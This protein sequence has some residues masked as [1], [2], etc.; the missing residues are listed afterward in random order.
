MGVPGEGPASVRSLLPK[1]EQKLQGPPGLDP[2]VDEKALTGTWAKL[3]WSVS[4]VRCMCQ[5]RGWGLEVELSRLGKI[6][7]GSVFCRPKL[8]TQTQTL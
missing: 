3:Y 5:A 4:R 8:G 2:G 7:K 6:K 1:Q